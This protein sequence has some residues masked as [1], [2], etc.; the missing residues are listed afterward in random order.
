M[1]IIVKLLAP[2]D[3]SD[4]IFIVGGVVIAGDPRFRMLR[5]PHEARAIV[6]AV[7]TMWPPLVL[8]YV[9][10]GLQLETI[11]HSR[12][13]RRIALTMLDPICDELNHLRFQ[14]DAR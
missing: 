6:C 5:H 13:F 8:A 12:A 9:G 4:L 10:E 7:H 14:L 1:V 3:R 2:L 11:K